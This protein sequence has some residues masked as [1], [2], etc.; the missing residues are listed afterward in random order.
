MSRYEVVP[1]EQLDRIPVQ[2][3]GITWRPVRRRFGITAFG[4]NAYTGEAG[5]AVVEDHTESSLG[6]EELYVVVSGRARFE[7]DGES[8][9]APAGTIVAISEPG[10]RRHA[11]AEEPGTAVLAVGGKPGVHDTSP[12]EYF[13]AAYTYADGGDLD[14]GIAELHAGLADLPDHPVLLYHLACLECRAGR[15][16]EAEGHLR[17]ALEARPDLR[18]W[19]AED[20]DLA[21]IRD[22]FDFTGGADSTANSG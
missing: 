17:Q 10:V 5:E 19:A 9:D 8:V 2:G 20:G 14:R 16:E 11:V 15:L 12:W 1:I 4:V 22:R 13:F 21:V 18:K 6:H 7:L 3:A